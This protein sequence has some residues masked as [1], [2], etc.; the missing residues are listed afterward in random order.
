MCLS[1]W[2]PLRCF[3]AGFGDVLDDGSPASFL[4]QGKRY[5]ESRQHADERELGCIRQKVSPEEPGPVPGGAEDSQVFQPVEQ[6]LLF[7]PVSQRPGRW[8]SVCPTG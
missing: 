6:G 7:Q 8:E 5:A 4:E 2:K 1:W 3:V